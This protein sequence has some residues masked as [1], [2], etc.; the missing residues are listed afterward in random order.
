MVEWLQN[1][2]VCY[3]FLEVVTFSKLDRTRNQFVSYRVPV[4]KTLR[5]GLNQLS[6][7]FES[8]YLKVTWH[9]LST[10]S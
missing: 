1:L 3:H 5:E 7:V 4:K 9:N 10:C 8:A 6:L 2:G